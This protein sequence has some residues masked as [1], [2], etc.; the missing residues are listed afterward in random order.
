MT[1]AHQEQKTID[2]SGWLARWDAQQ[3]GYLPDREARF[4]VMF[5]A[6]EQ[7]LPPDFVALDLCC[8][9]GSLS[10]RL[11][12]RFPQARAIGVDYDPVLLKLGREALGDLDGRMQWLEAD[13][14]DPEWNAG[15]GDPKVDAVLS[16][17]ALHWLGGDDLARVYFQLGQRLAP[18]GVFINGDNMPYAPNLSAFGKI[19]TSVREARWDEANFTAAGI[20][21]WEQWWSALRTEPG[22]EALVA[23]RDS[24]F[25]PEWRAVWHNTTYEFQ[26]AA[27]L[28]SG[29][30]QVGTIWQ[31]FDNRILLAIR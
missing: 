30:S 9:P 28:E 13:L 14:R 26:V 11:L 12:E 24:R 21:N 25:P 29:F 6:L 15:L 1:I 18:G 20:D 31:V 4:E 2:W 23:E 7:L 10:Q 22:M 5:T 3:T 27:L 16:T 17:T 8:G 19:A